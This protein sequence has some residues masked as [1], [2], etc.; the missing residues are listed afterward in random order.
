MASV[1][2]IQPLHPAP[3]SCHPMLMRMHL[4][5][6]LSGG[7]TDSFRVLSM[8]S[9]QIGQEVLIVERPQAVNVLKRAATG[10]S[11]HGQSRRLTRIG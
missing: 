4:L 3:K 9:R 5:A 1:M 8:V 2:D 7:L 10:A 6:T 11:L